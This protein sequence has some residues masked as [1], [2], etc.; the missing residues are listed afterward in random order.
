[1]PAH[2]KNSSAPGI[3]TKKGEVKTMKGERKEAFTLLDMCIK[4]SYALIIWWI[5]Q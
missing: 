1:M 3:P 4:W 5:M 2:A